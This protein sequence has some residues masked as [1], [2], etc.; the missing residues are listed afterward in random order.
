MLRIA[1]KRVLCELRCFA[2][3]YDSSDVFRPGAEATLMVAS[4]EKLAQASSAS[5]VE[6]ADAFGGV[7]LVTREGK[8]IYV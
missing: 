7:E 8:Q 2:E 4:V 1:H 5:D 6:R 3:S